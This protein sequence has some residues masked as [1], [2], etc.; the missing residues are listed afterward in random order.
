MDKNK[1]RESLPH[2]KVEITIYSDG[3]STAAAKYIMDAVEFA[4]LSNEITGFSVLSDEGYLPNDI[5][6]S[7]SEQIDARV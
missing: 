2:K 3:L 4:E 7:I 5:K 1:Y 6:E